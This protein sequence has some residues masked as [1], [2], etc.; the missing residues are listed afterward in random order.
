[1]KLA[2]SSLAALGLALW[3]GSAAASPEDDMRSRRPEQDV[4]YFV[5]PD[6]FENGDTANDK[7]GLEG[8]RLKTGFDPADKG[9]YH[10]GDLKGLTSRLDYIQGLGAS[11][12][13]VGPIFRN[14]P[15]QGAKGEESAG[16]HGYWI[17]DFTTVD[18][19]FGTDADFKAL[20]DAAHA[21]GMKVYMDIIANHT[22]DVIQYAEAA[23]QGFPYRSK[24]QYPFSTR[25]GT[26][27]RPINPGFAGDEDPA[28]ENWSKLTDPSFAYTPLVPRAER[29]VKVP[30]WLNDPIFYHNRGNTDWKGESAQYGDFV[31]LDDLATENPR[32]VAGMIDIY[33]AWIDRFGIDGFR[34]DTARH[35]NP[36]FWRAFVPAM[37]AR[38][39]ARGIHN[40]HVFG[41]IA[42]DDYDPAL[43]AS[44]TRSAGLPAVLDFAFMKGAITAL[45][46]KE[47]TQQLARMVE[48]DALYQGGKAAALQLPTF[49]GNHDAGRI[50]MFIRKAMPGISAEE[51]LARD[52]LAHAL[53]LTLRGVPTIYS[54]DEQGFVGAGN[55]QL[56]RQDMFPSKVAAYNSETLVGTTATTAEAN[57]D[58]SHPLYRF[59]S[60]LAHL[61]RSTPALTSGST[62]L[63][64]SSEQPGLFAVSRFDP[65]TGGE[66]LLAFN[67][68]TLALTT[69]VAVSPASNS[70]ATLA[71]ANCAAKP[72]APGSLT[73]QLP[74]LGFTVCAARP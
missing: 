10:G 64:A 24:A 13:W 4:I 74:P 16:Y 18:P 62:Q 73:V 22:A 68:S 21:R 6:R 14:K 29:S 1:M 12:I 60:D 25:G 51:L 54:G 70:F 34:I 23:A 43:L 48:D 30:A 7:G 46:G 15:V 45:S 9:F 56:A 31:G 44:W 35:V 32:V 36:A 49:L 3:H 28:P 52:K 66:V 39:K 17:T 27:G 20:V 11:A 53:L 57:F 38:A 69:Q 37:V 59:I 47:G 19:H 5:L 33:G 72:S 58:T 41:E 8:D 67:T 71:G 42:T 55:D 26:G 50:A 63:R 40:F 2:L 61:R 65:E